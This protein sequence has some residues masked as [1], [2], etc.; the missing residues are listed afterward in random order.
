MKTTL[1]RISLWKYADLVVQFLAFLAMLL[2][3]LH[4]D[5]G[6]F[7]FFV[8][9]A[10]QMISCLI[11]SIYFSKDIPGYRAGVFI[12]RLFWSVS[13][14]WVIPSLCSAEIAVGLLYIMVLLGP[15]LGLS[16]FI[17]TLLEAG[18]YSKARKPYY[19]L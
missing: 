13:I 7:A 3:F 10:V 18:Y 8:E 1:S 17:I 11:W 4:F 14:I 5:W 9:A 12:R 19:L 15:V 6:A 16:Y 2:L